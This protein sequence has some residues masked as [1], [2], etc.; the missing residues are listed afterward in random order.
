MNTSF[1]GSCACKKITYQCE[2]APL[3]MF[4]CHCEQCQLASG[5]TFVAAILVKESHL[6][7]STV[8][9][10]YFRSVGDSGRWTDR[11][12][13]PHCGTPMFAKGEIAPGLISIKPGTLT[14]KTLFKPTIDT[15]CSSAP[16][17][18]ALDTQIAKHP[19][20]P[21]LLNNKPK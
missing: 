15:W 17:W 1:I 18:L 4:N 8:T 21:N 14:D 10:K 2:Q 7:F 12:F 6:S 16:S 20:T 13:C 3:A 9:P 11:G 19:K 5:G